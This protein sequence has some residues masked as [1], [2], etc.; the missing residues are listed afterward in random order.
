MKERLVAKGMK[1]TYL[2][3]YRKLKVKEVR[4]ATSPRIC[5]LRLKDVTLSY[6]SESSQL[7]NW[8]DTALFHASTH[9]QVLLSAI[10]IEPSPCSKHEYIQRPM[11]VQDSKKK[12]GSWALD[13]TWA[14]SVWG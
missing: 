9:R 3:V 8:S 12:F 10:N 14:S 1:L 4:T 2:C 7:L 5:E 13:K 6:A 11:P